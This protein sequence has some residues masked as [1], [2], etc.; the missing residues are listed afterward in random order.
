VLFAKLAAQLTLIVDLMITSEFMPAFSKTKFM[1]FFFFFFECLNYLNFV[2]HALTIFCVL[3][4][5]SIDFL[6]TDAHLDTH[7]HMHIYMFSYFKASN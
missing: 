5:M 7:T 3:L 1:A 2:Y 6:N 4:S